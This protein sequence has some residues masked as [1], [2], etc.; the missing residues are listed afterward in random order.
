[1]L[2]P[3]A[4]LAVLLPVPARAEAPATPPAGLAE[5][6]AWLTGRWTYEGEIEVPGQGP[7]RILLVLEIRTDG[8]LETTQE[9]TLASA[10]AP[11]AALGGRLT[12]GWRVESASPTGLRL[13]LEDALMSRGGGEP[14][15]PDPAIE[16]MT[17]TVEPD[18]T[19]L[20]A[21]LGI[22]WRR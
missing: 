18:G 5:A 1:M 7:A 22:P 2:R 15:P 4:L 14:Q 11:D 17:F 21:D 10:S 6:S 9:I 3:L 20:D 12:A 8:T 19:L 13:T 16:A